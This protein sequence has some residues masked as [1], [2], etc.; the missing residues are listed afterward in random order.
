VSVH[1]Y[2]YRGQI[3]LTCKLTGRRTV[4][5][6]RG[7]YEISF[8]VGMGRRPTFY[9][10][11]VMRSVLHTHTQWSISVRVSM[12]IMPMGTPIFWYF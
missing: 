2:N 10:V 1:S 4:E 9:M 5:R 8:W 12:N 7:M 6:L 11:M 3:N